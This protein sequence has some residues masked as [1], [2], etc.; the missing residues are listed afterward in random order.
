LEAAYGGEMNITFSG[1]NSV[2]HSCSQHAN[3]TLLQNLRCDKTAYIR[4]PF[5]E[6]NMLFNQL[7]DMPHLSGGWI[8]LAKE[9]YSPTEIV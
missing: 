4:V 2:G 1:N 3:Y 9:K 6:M 5:I 8:T 7:L